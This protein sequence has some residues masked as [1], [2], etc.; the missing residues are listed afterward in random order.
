M[1]YIPSVVLPA[2]GTSNSISTVKNAKSLINVYV[3]KAVLSARQILFWRIGGGF[4]GHM[5]VAVQC[6]EVRVDPALG[7]VW[8]VRGSSRGGR[9]E[10]EQWG[11]HEWHMQRCGVGGIQ[12]RPRGQRKTCDLST[13]EEKNGSRTGCYWGLVIRIFNIIALLRY[14]SLTMQFAHLKYTFQ[15]LLLC[16]ELCHHRPNPLQHFH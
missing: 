10:S 1:Y 6:P 4:A 7:S 15:W 2:G 9:L 11:Q 13:K 14:N 5:R 12:E 8:W 16:S 3:H